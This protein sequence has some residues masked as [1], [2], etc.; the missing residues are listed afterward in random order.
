MRAGKPGD[1]VD[2]R[3]DTSAVLRV[4]GFGLAFSIEV[5]NLATGIVVRS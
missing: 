1:T 5:N 4:I 3:F 2:V